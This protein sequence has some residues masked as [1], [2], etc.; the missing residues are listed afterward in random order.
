[1]AV[2]MALQT[3]IFIAGAVAMFIAWRRTSDALSD[4]KATAEAQVAELRAHLD[5][6]AHTVDAT[7][8]ALLRGTDSVDHVMSDVR[9]AMGT[10]RES[11]G[12]VAS[13][14][15]APR[16]ALAIGLWQ[17]YQ[18]WRRRRAAQQRPSTSS[19][20][21]RERVEGRRATVTSEL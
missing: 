7:S 9:Q 12:S 5:R 17:G 18:F 16:A 3:V 8:R 10:M 1:M 14:V 21:S 15:S 6:M 11:V 4:A 13:V 19:G 20:Q 2:C